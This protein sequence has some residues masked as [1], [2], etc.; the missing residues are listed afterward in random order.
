MTG[1]SLPGELPPRVLRFGVS[2][3]TSAQFVATLLQSLDLDVD[4]DVGEQGWPATLTLR[5][6]PSLDLWHR[7]AWRR[8]IVDAL[9]QADPDATLL[10]HRKRAPSLRVACPR[11]ATPVDARQIH[12]YPTSQVAEEGIS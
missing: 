7:A 5:P 10:R 6:P 11:A 3:L 8:V 4:F 1:R 12:A 2:S 9:Q